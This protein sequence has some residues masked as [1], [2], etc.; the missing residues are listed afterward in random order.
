MNLTI[1]FTDEDF[2]EKEFQ[3]EVEVGFEYSEY[4]ADSDG[5]RGIS[6]YEADWSI[7]SVILDGQVYKPDLGLKKRI[8][9]FVGKYLDDNID[10]VLETYM[11]Q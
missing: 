8:A 10:Y 1:D 4:G 7:E 2:T 11:S 9:K 3:I 6:T 5:N